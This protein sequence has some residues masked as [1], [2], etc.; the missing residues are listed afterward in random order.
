MRHH[1][2]LLSSPRRRKIWLR[3][4]ANKEDSS[5]SVN[6][7]RFPGLGGK[8]NVEESLAEPP[9]GDPTSDGFVGH[10]GS[11]VEDDFPVSEDKNGSPVAEKVPVAPISGGESNEIYD[12]EINSEVGRSR[13]VNQ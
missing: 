3:V 12:I 2:V 9:L 5:G 11:F 4:E 8:E 13:V 7:I 1:L 6:S 10:K